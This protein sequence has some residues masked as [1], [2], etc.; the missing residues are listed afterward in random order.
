MERLVH[1]SRRA[2]PNVEKPPLIAVLVFKYDTVWLR[3][4]AY[5]PIEMA[6]GYNVALKFFVVN[7]KEEI[8]R[9]KLLY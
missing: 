3:L 9:A 8:R 5:R 1:R 7:R 2:A 6:Q 4:T